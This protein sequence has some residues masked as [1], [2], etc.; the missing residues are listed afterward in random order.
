MLMEALVLAIVSATCV[1]LLYLV[2]DVLEAFHM[3]TSGFSKCAFD[4]MLAC[5]INCMHLVAQRDSACKASI[6]LGRC[7]E[8][9]SLPAA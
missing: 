9:H 8:I 1:Y 7:Q 3:V 4:S 6:G 5:S 2:V